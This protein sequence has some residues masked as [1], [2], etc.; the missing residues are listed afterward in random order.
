[1]VNYEDQVKQ[2]EEELT[3]TDYNKRTQHHIGLVKA[4]IARLREKDEQRRSGGKKG[5]GYSVRKSGD[6][7]AVLLGFP[8][9]GKS[10]LLNALTNA[11]SPVGAYDFTTL[12][13]IPGVME[14]QHASIQVLDVPGIVRGAASGKGRGRE[15]L[16]VLRSADL[17]IILLDVHKPDHHAAL[18]QEI[19]EAHLRINQKPAIVKIKKTIR[20]GVRVGSTVTLH[21]I[22][23][24]T[25][26]NILNEFK[27]SNADVL[28]REDITIDQFIDV[29]EGNKHY[30]S[31][32]VVVNK[33][34]SASEEQIAMVKQLI[35]PDIMISANKK[36]NIE[37]L[38]RKMFDKL[39]FIRLY[40]KEPGKMADMKEPMI[41]R[42]G[43]TL[44]DV[45]M[46]L[47]KDFVTKFRYARIWGK[48]VKFEGQRIL[49][50][51]HRLE[52][53]DIIELHM[54]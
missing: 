9:V 1:M 25:I 33:I 30:V 6:A 52:D 35:H 15:V 18:L 50:L 16:A 32:I 2:L 47:H 22:D 51:A 37:A 26:K 48:S 20:G 27:M 45:C 10:T 36:S 13:V 28:I 41:G 43:N 17:V 5:E 8:S 53:N 14:Y 7:T 49:K 39:E 44:Q 19:Y 31:A 38:K 29:I 3:K 12:D 4:K 21:H 54:K 23:E 34:D 46:K 24:Q 40:M 42:R 11:N